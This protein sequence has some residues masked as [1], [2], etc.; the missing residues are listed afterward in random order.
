VQPEWRRQLVVSLSKVVGIAVTVGLVVGGL[1][2]AGADALGLTDE[3]PAPQ[4]DRPAPTGAASATSSP[5]P[6]RSTSPSSTQ[7]STPSAAPSTKVGT[8]AASPDRQTDTPSPVTHEKRHPRLDQQRQRQ[9]HADRARHRRARHHQ[10]S[11]VL[12]M[13]ASP[14]HT[15]KYGRVSL[16][17]RYP[18][19]NGV[20]L[21]VQ[22]AEP[23]WHDFPVTVTVRGGR[24]HT[25]VES[26]YPGP[27]RF[28]VKDK[29]TGT[30]SAPVTVW[31]H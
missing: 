24:F 17:G 11:A 27:N 21:Q 23:H 20:T 10:Q 15:H 4:A 5:T 18:G 14:R 19:H 30:T 16:S 3:D 2:L 29:R 6:S 31:V 13:S 8:R 12:T 26:G 7:S 22:R 25:W 9:S 28:R 1:A